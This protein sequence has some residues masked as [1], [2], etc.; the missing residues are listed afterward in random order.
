MSPP[1]LVYSP[2]HFMTAVL[3]ASPTSL[4]ARHVYSPL[5][6]GYTGEI[7]RMTKPKSQNVRNRLDAFIGLPLWYHSVCGRENGVQFE[8]NK[9]ASIDCS[10]FSLWITLR[11]I[12]YALS[13]TP[14]PIHTQGGMC[15]ANH[16]S[17][18]KSH[19]KQTYL[20]KKFE[21]THL[22]TRTPASY[23]CRLPTLSLGSSTGVRRASK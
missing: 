14:L 11:T 1:A 6:S 17:F 18:T 4:Y 3:V 2:E 23:Q 12:W 15:R 13:Y 21:A 22:T 5:S 10:S 20:L 7:S 16:I 9:T 19:Y 8:W